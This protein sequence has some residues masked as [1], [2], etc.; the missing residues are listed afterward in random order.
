MQAKHRIAIARIAGTEFH[1][2][3]A[4][5]QVDTRHANRLYP[6]L[7]GPGDYG[8]KIL[9]ELLA[10]QMTMRINHQLCLFI[11]SAA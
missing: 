11:K 2:R 8:L 9:A 7:S 5:L 10:I 1:N 3:S 4:R 6:S